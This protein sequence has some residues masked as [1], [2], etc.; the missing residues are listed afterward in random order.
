MEEQKSV[1]KI[2]N[3]W[4]L[5]AIERLGD[6]MIPQSEDFPSFTQLGCIEHIDDV[7]GYAPPEETGDLKMLLKVLAGTP[8][9][10]LKGIIKLMME[11][12]ALPESIAATFRLMDTGLRGIILTL[13]FS[14]K[15]GKNYQGRN[16]LEIIGYEI[17]RIPV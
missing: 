3:D 12:K 4:E 14:G 15:T 11:N 2:L 5:K 10:V 7:L 17:N 16:P 6:L 9:S 13:Y 8:E 1:S